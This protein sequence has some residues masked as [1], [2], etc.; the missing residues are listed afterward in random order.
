MYRLLF[1]QMIRSRLVLGSLLLVGLLGALG[2]LIGHQYL[3]NKKEAI[4]QVHAYQQEHMERHVALHQD[5]LGLLL[6]YLQFA[7]V[8]PH[9]PLAG[10]SIG[11]SD[12]HPNVQRITIKT[13][14]G[15][16]YDTD[17]VNPV[18]LQSGNLDL[19]FVLLYVFP[20]LIIV[21]SFNILSE[22]ME[23]GTWTL[24]AVQ[25]RSKW[26]YLRTKF[27]VRA[28]LVF[29]LWCLL[30]LVA[31]S[32]L[33]V[34]WN[35][36][37]AVVA[38]LSLA[39]LGFWFLLCYLVIGLKGA[40]GYNAMALLAI[41][42]FLLVLCPAALSAYLSKAYPVPEALTT[43]IKQ[44][45]GY[46]TKWDTDKM[47]TLEA[48]YGHYPQFKSYGYPTEG[49][50]W[51]WYYAMQQLGDDD[52]AQ[53]TKALLKKMRAREK[54]SA[55][56]S[57]LLPNVHLQ[58]SF[59]QLAGTSLREHLH[60]LEGTAHYH[61]HLRLFF[62]PKIFSNAGVDTVPWSGFVPENHENEETLVPMSAFFPMAMALLLTAF[63]C[64]FV[65]RR[66]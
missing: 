52:A 16:R 24:V 31:I 58:L 29:A 47:E 19:A 10:F 46:H 49:F 13:L 57:S 37:L 35:L 55:Q 38:I 32:V 2:I 22:E 60:F 59:N 1:L 21:L 30:L 56:L 62:Y 17:L 63:C 28:F 11:Q 25:A 8:K 61:E 42:L 14:E 18:S 51:L 15:Q 3:K 9:K 45:D 33:E 64:W 6:Y 20:L 48:F 5:D 4:Q 34:P 53:D 27:A 44:R 40:T 7:Y 26:A 50:T 65:Y 39:Y 12:I 36:D 23:R 43:M 66:F 54:A 41:W